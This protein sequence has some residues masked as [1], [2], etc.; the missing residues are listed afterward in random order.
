MTLVPH[1]GESAGPRVTSSSCCDIHP[2]P[3]M[4]HGRGPPHTCHVR[5]CKTD[6]RLNKSRR[7]HS[8]K[9]RSL[10]SIC[11]NS[12]C[13]RRATLG[14]ANLCKRNCWKC[15]KGCGMGASLVFSKSPAGKLGS[16]CHNLIYFLL[17]AVVILWEQGVSLKYVCITTLQYHSKEKSSLRCIEIVIKSVKLILSYNV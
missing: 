1:P 10:E 9:A 7:F 6:E 17:P 3:R 12:S 4:V 5:S 14:N 16:R 11:G 15:H 2:C 13:E 8:R